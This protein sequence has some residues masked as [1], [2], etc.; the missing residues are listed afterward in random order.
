MECFKSHAHD[1]SSQFH[2]MDVVT[3]ALCYHRHTSRTCACLATPGWPRWLAA[4]G[5]WL[6]L[7]LL[8]RA[9]VSMSLLCP[10]ATRIASLSALLHR[11]SSCSAALRYN[12]C[13]RAVTTSVDTSRLH[14]CGLPAYLATTS[15]LVATP[16][17]CLSPGRRRPL[18]R[19]V[20]SRRWL[21][22][23]GIAAKRLV[24]VLL[25]PFAVRA[26]ALS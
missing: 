3:T 16:R 24:H 19:Y 26:C 7:P 17:C 14:A 20:P 12:R 2:R 1:I 8:Q 21:V 6:L 25:F 15:A 23:Y 5:V 11:P 13:C 18:R 9:P 10:W 4:Q 22:C